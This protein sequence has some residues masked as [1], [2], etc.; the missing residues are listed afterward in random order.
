MGDRKVTGIV[1]TNGLRSADN[2]RLER[3]AGLP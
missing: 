3:P 1:V 2:V